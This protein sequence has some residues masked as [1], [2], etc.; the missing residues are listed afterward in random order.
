MYIGISY[1]YGSGQGARQVF[2]MVCG[3]GW[4]RVLWVLARKVA[5][6]WHRSLDWKMVQSE[7][8]PGMQWG[9]VRAQ[10]NIM[11]SLVCLRGGRGGWVGFQGRYEQGHVVRSS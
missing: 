4:Q 8:A 1:T 3:S 10:W 9:W 7:R 2:R 11:C 6:L 5:S